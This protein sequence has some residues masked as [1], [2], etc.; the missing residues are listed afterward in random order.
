MAE[1]SVRTAA[2]VNTGKLPEGESAFATRDSKRGSPPLNSYPHEQSQASGKFGAEHF[3]HLFTN[4]ECGGFSNVKELARKEKL[5]PPIQIAR[6]FNGL[7][8]L[9]TTPPTPAVVLRSG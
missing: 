4:Y 6:D 3:G 8:R 5:T 7:A 9:R 1:M 2:K